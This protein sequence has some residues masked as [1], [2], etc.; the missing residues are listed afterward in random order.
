M[1]PWLNRS[2]GEGSCP[3]CPLPPASYGSGLRWRL[4]QFRF[5]VIEENDLGDFGISG[6]LLVIVRFPYRFDCMISILPIAARNSTSDEDKIDVIT[7]TVYKNKINYFHLIHVTRTRKFGQTK[8]TIC[9]QWCFATTLCQINRANLAFVE[10]PHWS[11]PSL[12][13]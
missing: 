10:R 9:R 6:R 12:F 13:P 11:W 4:I 3:P 8:M 2:G 7:Q 5:K 1:C